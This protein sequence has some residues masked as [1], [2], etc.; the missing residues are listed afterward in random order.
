M[1]KTWIAKLADVT[2]DT[3][4][5]ARTPGPTLTRGLPELRR[6]V[7]PARTPSFATPPLRPQSGDHRRPQSFASRRR[8]K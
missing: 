7:K 6:A 3:A 2:S 8:G 5:G 1:T 4:A